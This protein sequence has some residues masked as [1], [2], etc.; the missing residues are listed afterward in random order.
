MVGDKGI[1]DVSASDAEERRQDAG[2]RLHEGEQE[3]GGG[4]VYQEQMGGGV[5][6]SAHLEMQKG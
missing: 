6:T 3:P 2:V 1:W 5:E 4:C